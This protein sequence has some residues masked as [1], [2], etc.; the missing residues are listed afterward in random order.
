VEHPLQ[1]AIRQE[2]A[3]L[4]GE[5]VIS[6]TVDGCG[7]PLFAITTQ[8]FASWVRHPVSFPT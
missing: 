8:N 5:S 1:I 7:A 2:I 6:S 3:G 4:I